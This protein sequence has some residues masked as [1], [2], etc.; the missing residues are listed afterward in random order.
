MAS[1]TLNYGK[2]TSYSKAYD[3]SILLKSFNNISTREEELH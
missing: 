3:D 1:K 2:V